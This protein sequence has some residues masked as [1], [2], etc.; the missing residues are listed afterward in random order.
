MKTEM[1]TTKHRDKKGNTWKGATAKSALVWGSLYSTASS[2]AAYML[3][4]M[5]TGNTP[6]FGDI[7]MDSLVIFPT[8]GAAH[9]LVK[10]RVDKAGRVEENEHEQFTSKKSKKHKHPM[11]LKK[12]A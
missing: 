2:G 1:N 3:A 5:M 7:F 9:G 12:A 11:R 4:P 10:W 8:A 6:A